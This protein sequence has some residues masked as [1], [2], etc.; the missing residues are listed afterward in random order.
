M[1]KPISL[2][3][4][5]SMA[6]VMAC[7]AAPSMATFVSQP[8]GSTTFSFN[9]SIHLGLSNALSYHQNGIG[10]S[11]RAF[12]ASGN[13]KQID[14]DWLTGA[15]VYSGQVG[16]SCFLFVCVPTFDLDKAVNAGEYLQLDF[17]RPVNLLDFALFDPLDLNFSQS[18]L[19]NGQSFSFNATNVLSNV[20]SISFKAG[21]DNFRLKS[22][23]V[24]QYAP[25]IPE[26]G[27]VA[28]M[29]LG[30]AGL[31]MVVR[32]RATNQA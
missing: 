2:I 9:S 8:A 25:P 17:D 32:R 4:A 24:S 28:L 23:T 31:A 7:A 16:Q 26:P 1:F 30:L 13:Q 27:S 14:K 19:I 5:A 20:S 18:L 12:D 22:V 29:G 3:R 10:L 11:M 15:G 21:A 6:M